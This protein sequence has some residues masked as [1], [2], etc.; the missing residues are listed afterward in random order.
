MASEIITRSL[1]N[2]KYNMVHRPDARGRTPRYLVNDQLKP[3]GVTTILGKT[4]SKDLTSWAVNCCIDYLKDKI[5]AVTKEDLEIAANEYN[6]LRDAGGTAGSQAHEMAEAYMKGKPSATKSPSP[7]ARA[8]FEAFKEWYEKLKPEVINVE[9]VVYSPSFAYAG[10]YDALL[11]INGRTY[12]CDL[13]TTNPSKRAPDG[14]YA[15]MFLQLGAYSLAHKEQRL[16]EQEN[17]GSKLIEIDD[18]MVISAKKNGVLDIITAEDIDLSVE[19]C[20]EMWKRVV[21]IHH[22]LKYGLEKL[23]GK[24]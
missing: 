22:F 24:E 8:A 14:V 18:L 21:N 11:K 4:I 19:E 9:E 16:F 20:E 5:P 1:Y 7:E 3:K 13:K 10:T 6:R 17:G 15:E 12:L 2:G 23:G